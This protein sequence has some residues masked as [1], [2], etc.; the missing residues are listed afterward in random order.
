M[1]NMTVETHVEGYRIL[2]HRMEE[3]ESPR[4]SNQTA[5]AYT[6]QRSFNR[7]SAGADG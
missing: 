3:T 4:Q 7:E 2:T 5:D 1:Q 6:K